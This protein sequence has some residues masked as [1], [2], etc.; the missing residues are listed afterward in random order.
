MKRHMEMR[1]AYRELATPG[2]F[3]FTLSLVVLIVGLTSV[4]DPMD[5]REKMSGMQLVGF[6][7]LVSGFDFALCYGNGILVLYLAR[8]RSR[9]QVIVAYLIAAVILAAPCTVLFYGGYSML[10]GQRAPHAVLVYSVSAACG[11]WAAALSAYALVLRIER[12]RVRTLGRRVP[13]ELVASADERV[14]AATEPAASD[15]G[16]GASPECLSTAEGGSAESLLLQDSPGSVA[17]NGASLSRAPVAH[18]FGNDEVHREAATG[19]MKRDNSVADA[20]GSGAAEAL[21]GDVVCVHVSGHYIDV[22]TTTGSAVLLMRLADAMSALGHR[23]M[24]VHRSY[25]V[26]FSHMRRLVRCDHRTVLRLSDGQEVPVSRPYVS[27]VRDRIKRLV[28]SRSV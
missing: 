8:F 21:N 15:G 7:T 18:D 26:A 9:L 14:G 11:L 17:E 4:W 12:R 1:Y 3:M 5:M 22:V 13:P 16:A 28:G 10:L 20:G 23:G 6:T 25:W 19:S 24:Q 2:M 27:S